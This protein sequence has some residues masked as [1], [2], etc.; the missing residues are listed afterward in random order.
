MEPN[1]GAI[2]ALV[3]DSLNAGSQDE[4]DQVEAIHVIKAVK[5]INAGTYTLDDLS[6]AQRTALVTLA[7]R[8]LVEARGEKKLEGNPWETTD[9][10]EA[11]DQLEADV[12]KLVTD[13]QK[14]WADVL[15][16][17]SQGILCCRRKPEEKTLQHDAIVLPQLF[18]AEVMFRAYEDQ[19]HQGIDKVLGRI[20][21]RFICKHEP[22][23]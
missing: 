4:E 14:Q 6:R 20:R 13:F 22:C 5:L 15:F 19:A 11:E 3:A 9:S 10:R 21:Q 16:I 23:C 2:M 12:R 17:N 18:Q 1:Y 7:L 8:S